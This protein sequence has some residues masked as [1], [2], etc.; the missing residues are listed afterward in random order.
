MTVDSQN[1][2]P[3]DVSLGA[4]GPVAYYDQY[5]D[6]IRVVTHDRSVTEH[7]IDGFFTLH[8]CNHRGPFDPEYVGFTIKGVH[9]LF[10]EVGIPFA[11]VLKLADLISKLVAHRP[12]S[13]MSETLR[14][15]F[16]DFAASGDLR[17]DL[18]PEDRRLAA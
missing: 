4:F 2:L 17:I 16:K 18:Q 14:L 3:A 9:H 12:G 7:R 11:G 5:M 6:C 1:P 15:I 13:M 10:N 8:E